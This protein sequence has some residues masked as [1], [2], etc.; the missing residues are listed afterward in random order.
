M[1]PG[2]T[3][4]DCKGFSLI[5]LMVVVTIMALMV[6]FFAPNMASWIA[7][8]KVRATA[9]SLASELRLAQVEALR[10]NRQAVLALSND[11]PSLTAVPTDN[12]LNWYVRALATP[13]EASDP[14]FDP[15]TLYVHG[16][17]QARQAGAMTLNG[18]GLLCFNSTGRPVGTPMSPVAGVSTCNTPTNA[19]SPVTYTISRAGADRRLAVQVGLG[20]L[21]RLCDPDKKRSDG[22][23]DACQ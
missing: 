13:D 15:K 23:S 21:I 12:G 2:A 4:P 10:R 5:E 19:A 22:Q 18:P 9:E 14:G 6:V 16:S 11:T 20:G 1:S 7:N 17:Q 3:A 8:N